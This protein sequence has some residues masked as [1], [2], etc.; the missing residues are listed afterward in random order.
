MLKKLLATTALS[1]LLVAPAYAQ[2]TQP[3][4]DPIEAPADTPEFDQDPAADPLDAPADDPLADPVDD[5][6][7]D[8]ADDP[9]ADPIEDDGMTDDM[10][11]D[12]A[13]AGESVMADDIIGADLLGFDGEVIATVDDVVL[14]ASG[15]IES[16]LVDVG[17]FLGLGATTVAIPFADLDVATDED[18]ETVLRSQLTSDDL[19]AMPE[20]QEEEV[21]DI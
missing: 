1:A 18:G 8:P 9:M 21:D 5:P 20:Y 10:E 4:E 14:D 6:L 11:M 3:T 7:A 15:E 16:I 17:G 12:T 19:E 2:D 13:P